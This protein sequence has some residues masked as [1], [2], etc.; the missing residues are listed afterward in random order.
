MFG[1]DELQDL[2]GRRFPGGSFVISADEDLLMREVVGASPRQGD[3][4]HPI[5]MFAGPQRAIGITIDDLFAWC[6]SSS[7][8]GPMLGETRLTMPRPLR[9]ERRCAVTG[10]I[11][12]A[13]RKAGQRA[14]TF[15]VVTFELELTA[16]EDDGTR[17]A[18]RTSF[19]FPRRS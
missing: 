11:V 18:V 7:A 13:D 19:V 2:P 14:G 16:A 8:D 1:L 3:V 12:S 5:W 10:G 15:D 6:G 17:W 4:A 9:I